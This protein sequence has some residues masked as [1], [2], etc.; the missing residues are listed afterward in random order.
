MSKF[1]AG[2][3][4]G[5]LVAGSGTREST[6][7]TM[8]A[9]GAATQGD[10]VMM[11]NA[12]G[13]SL[14]AWIDIDAD[15]T[16]PTGALYVAS[17][18]QA[19]LAYVNDVTEAYVVTFPST[20]AATQ[21]DYFMIYDEAGNSTAVWFDID[22][23]G[24]APTGALY[25]G[26]DSQI[27][28]DIVGGGT[29]AQNGTLAYTA[30]NGN[31]TNVSFTDNL[32]GT[33]DVDLDNAGPASADAV[34]K[35]EDDSGAGSVSVGAITKGVN[36]TTA[37]AGGALLAAT[38]LTDTTFTD[39]GDG[40]V[41]FAADNIGDTTDAVPKDDDDAGAGSIGVSASD[42]SSASFPYES[43]GDS[44]TARKVNPDLVT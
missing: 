12:A 14:A 13:D 10:Y 28:V 11:Y 6:V 4:V 15:G 34:P 36:A 18:N 38:S 22:A 32:D 29:A 7:V 1:Q 30:M 39:N 20:A 43:P 24:T 27:E 35:N 33:V 42:G 44:P 17:D 26:S 9:V 41:T 5:L 40:T 16:A 25:V 2:Q 23:D 21:G 19:T 37:I 3:G 8:P 31:V